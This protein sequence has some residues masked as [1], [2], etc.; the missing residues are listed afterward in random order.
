MKNLNKLSR[1]AKGVLGIIYLF[2]T[3][4][5]FLPNSFSAEAFPA[6]R[7]LLT[8]YPDKI[9]FVFRFYPVSND[10]TARNAALAA[11]CANDQN[12]FWV[13]HDKLFQNRGQFSADDLKNYAIQAG[14]DTA[15]F[16]QCLDSRKFDKQIDNDLSDSL[17]LGVGGTPTFFLNGEKVEGAIPLEAWEKVLKFK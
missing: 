14:L 8:K 3:A 16:N 10:D 15:V 4:L 1:P 17:I 6:I 7:E 2:I 9:N 11:L 12:K 5:V 13:Y